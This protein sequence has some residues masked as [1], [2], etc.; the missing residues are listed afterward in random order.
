MGADQS[1][2]LR[3]SGLTKRYTVGSETITAVAAVDLTVAAGEV[4]AITGPSGSGKS[5]LLALLAGLETPDEGEVWL[6]GVALH[7]LGE[8]ARARLRRR[9]IGFVFQ[10]F[11]LLP[12]LSL[13]ENAALPLILDGVPASAW[14]PRVAQALA[15]VGLSHRAEHLPDQASVGEQQ[16]A[17]LARVLVTEPAVLFADEPTGSLDT[18]RGALVMAL[19]REAAGQGTTV[20]LVTHDPALAAQADRQIRLRDGRLEAPSS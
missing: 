15:R 18:A 19:L 14:A 13:A 17:A 6:D 9:R 2:A 16:R 1:I 4:V 5:T 20:L 3:A 12:V 10:T 11:N 8:D 7:S